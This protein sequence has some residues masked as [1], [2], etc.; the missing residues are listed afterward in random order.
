MLINSDYI[1]PTFL[2]VL[3]F[4]Q[5]LF[6]IFFNI[7]ALKNYGE[8]QTIYLTGTDPQC[9]YQGVPALN[10]KNQCIVPNRLYYN[11]YYVNTPYNMYTLSKTSQT[12]TLICSPLC[13]AAGGSI[14]QT[15]ACSKNITTYSDC[16]NDLAP[17]SGCREASK[18]LAQLTVSGNKI[19]Y[20]AAAVVTNPMQC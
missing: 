15:G 16:L 5:I 4:V 20:Y 13:T 2:L 12:N 3:I 18:P 1:T 17:V 7:S 14:L 8:N 9:Q 11:E 10:P 6:I 19:Y